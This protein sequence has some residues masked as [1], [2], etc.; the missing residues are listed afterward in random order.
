M[1]KLSVKLLGMLLALA[2]LSA[3]FIGCNDETID[4][5]ETGDNMTASTTAS[6]TASTEDP[7]EIP[8]IE[9]KNYDDDFFLRVSNNIG[10]DYFWVKEGGENVVSEALYTRQQKV[11]AHLGVEVIATETTGDHLVNYQEFMTSVKNKDGAIDSYFTNQYAGIPALLTGG[12]IQ[13]LSSVEGLELDAEY[14]NMSY[15]ESLSIYDKY[16]LGYNSFC[17]PKVYMLVFN[18]TMMEQYADSLGGA[19]YDLVKDYKWTVDRMIS[20]ANLVY[21]DQSGDGKT[22]DDIFGITGVQ[23]VPYTAFLQASDIQLVEQN[24]KGQYV[25]SVYN[26][27]N[28]AKTTALVEKLSDLAAGDS[29]WFRFRVEPTTIIPLT[30]G[31]TLMSMVKSSDLEGF[32]NYDI[33]FGVL[34][35][36]M[37]DE[38]QRN[39]GYRSIN[40]DG[41]LVLPS[42]LRKEQMIAE[43]VEMLAFYGAP[44]QT[45]VF[46]KMLG[47]QVADTP[48]DA[49][50]LDL[51]WDSVC[52]D[53][54]MTYSHIDASL[55]S[56]LYIL[57]NLT[58]PNGTDEIASYVAS[59]ERK[60]NNALDKFM[61]KMAK[62]K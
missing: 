17:V 30:S 55:D 24:E 20:L 36:P 40:Y 56:F 10:L 2:S 1:T 61:R 41:N 33:T 25:A 42:Y 60:A 57:P 48:D 5:V 35:Y 49:A 32:L 31:R 38:E 53:F 29:A 28:K 43:T 27:K 8:P 58:N 22:E 23:W 51:I 3:A 7:I 18:K 13:D 4:G 9:K 44:V 52:S 54:G 11:A 26:E 46:E 16:Y 34:P 45:A 14:W 19:V 50:M 6:A 37:F 21:V 39:V 15:M 62:A 47:K 12:Y 59:N